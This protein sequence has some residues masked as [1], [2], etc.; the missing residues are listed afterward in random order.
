M[1]IQDAAHLIGHDYPGGAGALADRM[2]ISR[3]VFN[4]KLNPNT[5]THHLTMVEALRMQQLAGRHDVLYAMAEALGFVCMPLPMDTHLDVH[6]EIGRVCK[7]FGEYIAQVTESLEDGDITPNEL[8]RCERELA[9]LVSVT[10]TLQST[11][12]MMSQRRAVCAKG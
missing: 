9:D 7:E 11:L 5:T 1:N 8:H 2:G 6:R 12:A 10:S 4:S 3:V